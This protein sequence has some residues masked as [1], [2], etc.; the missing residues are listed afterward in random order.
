MIGFFEILWFVALCFYMQVVLNRD[1]KY[2][3]ELKRIARQELK[4]KHTKHVP[5]DKDKV[6]FLSSYRKKRN[7][8]P[9]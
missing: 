5:I 2:R 1:K 6:V 7:I 9:A 3:K 4:R 8:N